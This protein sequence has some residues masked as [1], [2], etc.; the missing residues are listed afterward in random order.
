MHLS[1][2]SNFLQE[3]TLLHIF[4]L[5]MR[6][7][8]AIDS[9]FSCCT[10]KGENWQWQL[11]RISHQTSNN[12]RKPGTGTVGEHTREMTECKNKP[13]EPVPVLLPFFRA[14]GALGV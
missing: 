12:P 2:A 4:G 1:H 14:G 13:T 5:K 6:K 9:K 8:G 3:C 10:C 7:S 11:T